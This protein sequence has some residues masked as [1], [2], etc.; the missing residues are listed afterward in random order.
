ML[1]TSSYGGEGRKEEE[2]AN[3]IFFST[4]R[5]HRW[6]LSLGL[7]VVGKDSDS[8]LPCGYVMYYM[9]HV[10]Y[11]HANLPEPEEKVSGPYHH[12]ELRTGQRAIYILDRGSSPPTWWIPTLCPYVKWQFCESWP[13]PWPMRI[14]KSGSECSPRVLSC[15]SSWLD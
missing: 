10:E 3:P 4:S 11:E 1:L 2:G 13:W 12:E 6:F 7:P 15:S 5:F 8:A 14:Q 9:S